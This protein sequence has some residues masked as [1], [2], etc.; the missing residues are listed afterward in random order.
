[1]HNQHSQNGHVN[2]SHTQRHQL[3]RRNFVGGIAA[4]GGAALVVPALAVAADSTSDAK[5]A[6]TGSNAQ[7]G[8]AGGTHVV[9]DLAGIDVELP[10]D[11][12][13]AAVMVHPSFE[14]VIMLGAWDQVALTGNKNGQSGWSKVVCPAYANVPAVENAQEPNLEEL[15]S[16]GVD[17]VFFWDSYPDTIEK[18]KDLGI[19]VFTTQVANS[20]VQNW[21]QF[22]TF[23]KHEITGVA[24]VFGGEAIE[25]AKRWCDWVDKRAELITSKTSK[26]AK[27]DLPTVYYVRGPEATTAHGGVSNTRWLVDMAGGDLVTKDLDQTMVDVT[28]EQIIQWNPS[29]IVMGRVDN[30]EL[31]TEDPNFAPI[32]AVQDGNVFVNLHGLGPTDYCSDCFLLMEQIAKDLHPDL[33]EDLDMVAEVKDFFHEFYG[34]DLTDDEAQRVLTY[35]PPASENK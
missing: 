11:I 26:I 7:D 3:S 8:Q 20:G 35:Q 23:K 5:D 13:H 17:V 14:S 15:S 30:K 32:K 1:M 21:E 28:M 34:Y 2:A 16:A 12:K 29:H 19:P 10:V 25:R 33:F 22:L 6:P 18:I 24:E 9:N 4:L 27:E 31:V